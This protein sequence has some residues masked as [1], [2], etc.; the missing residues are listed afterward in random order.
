MMRN[1]S[2]ELGLYSGWLCVTWLLLKDRLIPSFRRSKSGFTSGSDEAPQQH[3]RDSPVH[4]P[5]F[6]CE[7]CDRTFGSDEAL[8][9]HLRDLPA[10]Q[11]PEIPLDIF[12]CSFSTFDYDSSLPPA[13]SY[14]LLRKHKGW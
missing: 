14:A 1:Q 5:S 13:T 12:F 11:V 3:L 8:Q 7:T 6:D 2:R 4:A 9:Q 10:Y